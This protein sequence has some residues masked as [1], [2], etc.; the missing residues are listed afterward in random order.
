MEYSVCASAVYGGLPLGQAI[1]R[2]SALGYL[3]YEFWGW[4]DQDLDLIADAQEKSNIKAVGMCTRM[5]ALND[6]K[7]RSDYIQGLEESIQMAKKLHCKM[8]IS[9]VGQEMTGVARKVQHN[10]IVEGLQAS[11]AVLEKAGVLLVVEPLNTRIDHKGYYL[12]R[13]EEGFE[14]IKEVGSPYV[15]L[16]FDVY[17]QQITEGNLIYNLTE[18]IDFI[19][20]IHIAGNPGRH[21]P[22]TNSEVHYPTIMR[23]LKAAG[24]EGYI[25]LEY[26]PVMDPDRGLREM[27]EECPI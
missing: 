26:F 27:M 18:N 9:Q 23:A 5:I 20:H 6:P 16:L 12:D 13:S 17:H 11:A 21:E 10:A 25:G 2:I 22:L 24:Y 8:L 7:R 14:I 19:G 4:W 1:E 15:K 3:A